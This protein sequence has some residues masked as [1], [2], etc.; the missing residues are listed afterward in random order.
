METN[1][2]EKSQPARAPQKTKATSKK[3]SWVWLVLGLI[4]LSAIPLAGGAFRPCPWCCTSWVPA[5]MPSWA[6]SSS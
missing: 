2:Y 6:R 4:L 1:L 5:S 3:R